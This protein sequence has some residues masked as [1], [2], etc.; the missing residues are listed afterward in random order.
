MVFSRDYTCAGYYTCAGCYDQDADCAC[1]DACDLGAHEDCSHHDCCDFNVDCECVRVRHGSGD[2]YCW[3]GPT[4]SDGA[5][6][7]FECS[8]RKHGEEASGDEVV[9]ED[10]WKDDAGR[11]CAGPNETATCADGYT[12]V[13]GDAPCVFTCCEGAVD[14]LTTAADVDAE[15]ICWEAHANGGGAQWSGAT[16]A[17]PSA[18]SSSLGPWAATTTTRSPTAHA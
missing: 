3:P 17:N 15:G 4:G 9:L 13:A 6:P 10:R 16:A 8:V 1:D 5:L 12:V 7:N 11:C 14:N 2:E 18:D